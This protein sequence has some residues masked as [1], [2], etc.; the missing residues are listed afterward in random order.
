MIKLEYKEIINEIDDIAKNLESDDNYV[1]FTILRMIK[2]ILNAKKEHEKQEQDMLLERDIDEAIESILERPE[3]Y[4][5]TKEHNIEKLLEKSRIKQAVPQERKER[6]SIVIGANLKLIENLMKNLES[7][8]KTNEN[9]TLIADMKQELK[10]MT[11]IKDKK[12]IA[13]EVRAMNK[14]IRLAI[15]SE[16]IMDK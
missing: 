7:M 16:I 9:K 5:D 1:D 3:Y 2:S 10:S 4:F 13:R 12:V 8:V 6:D 14:K 15:I 11:N